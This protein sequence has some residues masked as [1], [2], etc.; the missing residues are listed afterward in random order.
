[1]SERPS[2]SYPVIHLI[3]RRAHIFAASIGVALV[4]IGI[5]AISDGAPLWTGI[6]YAGGGV[7]GYLLLRSYGELAR[8]LLDILM[9]Q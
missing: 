9:P 8:I 2:L 1:M 5:W 3:A 7:I 6:T 4:A